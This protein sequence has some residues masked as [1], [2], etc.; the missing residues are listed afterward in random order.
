[1]KMIKIQIYRIIW[2]DLKKENILII[3]K[4]MII[5][6]RI[7]IKQFN[8][9]IIKFK[10]I[11]NWEIKMRKI[12]LINNRIIT[13]FRLLITILTITMKQMFLIQKTK[14]KIKKNCQKKK[15]SYKEF[16]N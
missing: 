12:N 13:Y 11:Y 5:L 1:M 10:M 7:L 8:K 3:Y 6:K 2:K 14:H 16:K 9:T 15:K 4:I